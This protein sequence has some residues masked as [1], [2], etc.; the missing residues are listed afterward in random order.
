MQKPIVVDKGSWRR[1]KEAPDLRRGDDEKVAT[2]VFYGY[3]VHGVQMSSR[4]QEADEL[5][6]DDRYHLATKISVHHGGR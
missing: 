6:P 3:V 4:D 2:V 5:R 1:T